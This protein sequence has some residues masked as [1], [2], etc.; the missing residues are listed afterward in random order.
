MYGSLWKQISESL[1]LC[2]V[3]KKKIV[4][5]RVCVCVRKEKLACVIQVQISLRFA[6]CRKGRQCKCVKDLHCWVQY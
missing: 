4:R 2:L 6:N 5:V 3:N 1:Q